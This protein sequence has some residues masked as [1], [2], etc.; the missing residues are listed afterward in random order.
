MRNLSCLFLLTL[1]LVSLYTEA[2]AVRPPLKP[3]NREQLQKMIADADVI[4]TGTIIHANLSK[5]LQPPLETVMIH[6]VM[7][8]ERILKGGGLTKS[9]AI[10]ESYQQFSNVEDVPDSRQAAEKT[11][12]ANIAGPSP[13]VGKYLDGDRIL[14]FL[15]SIHG[16]NQYRPLGSGNHDA[17]LG[18]FQITSEGVKSDRYQFDDILAGYA[19]SETDFLNFIISIKGEQR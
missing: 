9:I 12:T 11:V 1:F 17:Y 15:K 13:P 5:T 2:D 4:V 10:E 19:G 16:L 6:A 18:V 14:V 3:L 7:T 8:P